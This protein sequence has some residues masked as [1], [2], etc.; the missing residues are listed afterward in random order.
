MRT[1]NNSIGT[2][3]SVYF[4]CYIL[5]SLLLPLVP[6]LSM[7]V[8]SSWNEWLSGV[9][10]ASH[11]NCNHPNEKQQVPFVRY[12]DYFCQQCTPSCDV[13]W[14]QLEYSF[15]W[16]VTIPSSQLENIVIGEVRFLYSVFEII[17]NIQEIV[18]I[19]YCSTWSQYHCIDLPLFIKYVNKVIGIL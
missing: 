4:S 15:P 11:G 3:F 7:K 14:Y 8:L 16:V 9:T 13:L 1:I 12:T 17:H 18:I 2:I 19:K 5:S 10:I 6:K